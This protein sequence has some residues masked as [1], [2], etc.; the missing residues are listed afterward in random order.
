MEQ[1]LEICN[2][3]IG[4]EDIHKDNVISILKV[5]Y[6]FQTFIMQEEHKYTMQIQKLQHELD[7]MKDESNKKNSLN[8]FESDLHA[9]RNSVNTIM[10]KF[11]QLE[12]SHE[13]LSKR[14]TELQSK[15]DANTSNVTRIEEAFSSLPAKIF[16]K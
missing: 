14:I 9:L 2:D 10:N 16:K 11:E 6:M 1:I 7:A 5:Q 4:K 3:I 13:F 8:K 15:T 12:K